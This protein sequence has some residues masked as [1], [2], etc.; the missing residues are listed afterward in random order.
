MPLRSL[1]SA[2]SAPPEPFV[3]EEHRF[4]MGHALIVTGIPESR[5]WRR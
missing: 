3:P 5:N 1:R 2:F 4:K